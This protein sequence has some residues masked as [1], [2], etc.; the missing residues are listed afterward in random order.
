MNLIELE[1]K[2][3]AAARRARP[4]EGVPYAFEQRI[5]ARLRARPVMDLWAVWARGLW[6]A[7][8]PCVGVMLLLVGWTVLTPGQPVPDNDLA[9]ELENTILAAATAEHVLDSTW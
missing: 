9:Q 8:A 4:R 1:Q 7:A 2:L 5:M 3:F 6:R